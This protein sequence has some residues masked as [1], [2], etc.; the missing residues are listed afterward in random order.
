MKSYF[1][2]VEIDGVNIDYVRFGTGEKTLIMLPGLSYQKVKTAAFFLAYTYRIFTKEYM[3]Y[4]FDKKEEIPEG[5]TIKNMADDIASA[6]KLLHIESA[7][8]FG[9]S[10]GGMIAQYLAMDHPQLVDKA[11]FAVTASRPNE[12]MVRV[13]NDW[14][15]MAEQEDYRTSVI[16]MF[17][18]MYSQSYLQK[19]RWLFPLISRI[20]KPKDFSRF[21]ALAKSCLTCS[22]Y[23]ELQKISCPAF[24]IGGRQDAVVTGKA[25]EEIAEKLGCKIYMYENLGHAAYDEAVDF[26]R[27]VYQFLTE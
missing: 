17:E 4:V 2:N 18:K 27:R 21:I 13:L 12:T 9:V 16:D 5:Y 24:V 23:G 7:D 25:S 10:Q 22:C 11:V 3:V 19:Y 1:S 15:R 14:I 8:V 26:N 6:M 20:G